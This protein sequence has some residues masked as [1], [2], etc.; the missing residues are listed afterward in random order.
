[1]LKIIVCI[2]QVIDPEAP[3]SS[4]SVDTE[5]KKV[6]P[7]K[8]TPPV[9]NPFDENALEAALRLKD[10]QEVEITAISMGKNLSKAVLRKCLA[11]GANNLI[12]LEDDSFD[13]LDNY[14]TAVILTKTIEKIGAYDI[15]LCGRQSSDTDAGVTGSGIAELLGIPSITLAQKLTVD[16][17]QVRVEKVIPDGFAVHQSE[18]PV[19]I[20]VSN[21]IGELRSASLPA[22]M[23]A[24]K[25]EITTWNAN[26]IGVDV[27]T[28]RRTALVKLYQPKHEGKCEFIDGQS[29]EEK[30]TNLANKLR[31]TKLI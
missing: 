26:D 27:N 14:S 21:E 29:F 24:Q 6:I 31:E 20:T 12:L 9:L 10:S 3:V 7:P 28:L 11:A 8:G 2:K 19:L 23:A 25:K 30:G 5:A 1:M 22:I 4:F 15:I 17:K 13:N 18:M 16:G